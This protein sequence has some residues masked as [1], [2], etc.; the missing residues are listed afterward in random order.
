MQLYEVGIQP[1]SIWLFSRISI[2][3]LIIIN[4]TAFYRIHKEH[5][6]RTKS[7]FLHDLCRIDRQNADLGRKDQLIIIRNK[8]SGRT[9][10]V[11]VKNRTH[12]ITVRKQDRSRSVPWLHHRCI[13]MI[14]VFL[15]L[16]HCLIV[17]P[18]L[19]NR[20]HD[21]QWQIHTTHDKEF[22]CIVKHCGIGT[23]CID[24]RQDLVQL[25]VQ[26]LG[27]HILF[28]GKH[29]ICIT[30]DRI[31]LTVVHDKPVWMCSFP[32]RICIRG[33]TGVYDCDR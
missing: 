32:A 16:G 17:C 4:D 26:M 13:I 25:S 19:R 9:Q 18:R 8:I 12:H 29:L 6:A 27:F 1:F 10:T 33:E 24:H 14:E 31:D 11:T 2:L 22:Q 7:F 15:L 23:G 3:D 5:L 30:A 28:T 21:C 20:D